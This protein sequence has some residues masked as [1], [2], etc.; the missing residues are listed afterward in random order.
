MFLA[1]VHAIIDITSVVV[2]VMVSRWNYKGLRVLN[3]TLMFMIRV[4][5]VVTAARSY[6]RI[7][8]RPHKLSLW[9]GGSD[10]GPG[11]SLP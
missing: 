11:S 3:V 9:L 6:V 8:P 5:A 1:A 7:D 10:F 2:A 4:V